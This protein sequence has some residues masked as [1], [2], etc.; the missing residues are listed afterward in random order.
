MPRFHRGYRALV[1]D[2][3]IDAV[4]IPLPNELYSP[5]V[6]DAAD[7]VKHVLGEKPLALDSVVDLTLTASL[8]F[9]RGFWP[10]SIAAS[11]SRFDASTSLWEPG[12]SSRSPTPT[13]RRLWAR[14]SH[15]YGRSVHILTRTPVPTS[16]RPCSLSRPISMPDGR[17]FRSL[18]CA[19]RLLEP[20]EDGLAQMKVLDAV[21]G[22]AR[23][24]SSSSMTGGRHAL[25]ETSASGRRPRT[26]RGC[27]R[28]EAVLRRHA[29]RW[30]RHRTGC[31]GRGARAS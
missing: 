30:P 25:S 7:A 22:L 4:Y 23:S 9:P 21:L 11:S 15:G 27:A 16:S 10:R 6:T 24:R 12:E 5:W 8:R 1:D 14:R 29:R 17:R 26:R 13:S 31:A 20:G 2:P 19:G 28:S 18:G 3:E